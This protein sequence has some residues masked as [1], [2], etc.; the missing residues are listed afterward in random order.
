MVRKFMQH[1]DKE[2]IIKIGN[3]F[4]IKNIGDIT[5]D[6]K[7][8]LK[9][10]KSALVKLENIEQI[11]LSAIQV[12]QSIRRYAE[13]KGMDLKIE[14]QINNDDMKSLLISNGFTDFI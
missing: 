4:S 7:K 1:K 13:K 5:R 14:S 9:N 6:L 10:A 12:M 8:N 2:K 3:D 11:D